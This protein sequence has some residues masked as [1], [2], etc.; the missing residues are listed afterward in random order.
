[1]GLKDYAI[2]FTVSGKLAGTFNDTFAEA[3]DKIGKFEKQ[4][5]AMNKASSDIGS[6][7]GLREEGARLAKDAAN[8]KKALDA[9][10]E[11]IRRTA[12]PTKEQLELAR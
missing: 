7:I 5:E 4:I 8:K 6:L 1:M 10:S 2:A 12:N 9:V 3:G 11:S